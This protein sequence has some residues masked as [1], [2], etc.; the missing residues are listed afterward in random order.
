MKVAYI[1]LMGPDWYTHEVEKNSVSAGS[2]QIKEKNEVGTVPVPKI[3][4]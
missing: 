3:K 4:G 1:R 2:G